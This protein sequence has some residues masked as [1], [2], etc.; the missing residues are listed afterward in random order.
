M[1]KISQSVDTGLYLSPS[2]SLAHRECLNLMPTNPMVDGGV[3]QGGLTSMPGSSLFASLEGRPVG[4]HVFNDLL[5]VVRQRS[6]PTTVIISGSPVTV[7]VN[8]TYLFSVSSSGVAT[9]VGTFGDSYTRSAIITDNG[10]VMCI[11]FPDAESYFYDTTNG[12]VQITDT[13]FQG[14]EAEDGGVRSVCFIDGYFV[15]NTYEAIFNSSLV[16]TNDGKNFDALDFV[17]P[18]LREKARLVLSVRGELMVFGSDTS[19]TYSNVGGAD[20]PF[21]EIPGATIQKGLEDQVNAVEFD[22]SYFFI[23]S[24]L[25]ERLAIWRGIGGGGVSKIS[26]DYIDRQIIQSGFT[27]DLQPFMIDGRPFIVYSGA[28]SFAYDVLSS[29]I[30]GVPVWIELTEGQDDDSWANLRTV[31]VYNKIIV[32]RTDEVL[33]LDTSVSG[34]YGTGDREFT[35]SG[36]YLQ[37]QSEALIVNRLELV[38]E[39]GIGTDIEVDPTQVNPVVLME[40]SDDGANTWKSAGTR[41]IG[42]QA[43]Y[44][45]RLVWTRLG[46]APTSRIFRFTCNTSLPVNFNRVDISVE[47]GYRNA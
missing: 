14:Y 37:N 42:R 8:V 47:A 39:T 6:E 33:Y 25:N 3:A 20:F 1:P 32:D 46:R 10:N 21:Q 38:M 2:S 34:V 30:K 5:Y 16:T 17:Q 12:L 28:E 15:F 43:V 13:V 22:N 41:E 35:F 44:E 9:E 29:S 19:K 26:T 23:G 24:G 31:E 45:K 7:Y 40:Y 18:F 4:A 27:A 36:S 11:V